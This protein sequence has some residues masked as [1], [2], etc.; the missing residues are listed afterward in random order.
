MKKYSFLF[1]LLTFW[2]VANAQQNPQQPAQQNDSAR[3]VVAQTPPLSMMAKNYGDSVV[4]MWHSGN[5]ALW[6]QH[7]ANGFI[8]ERKEI[9]EGA[10]P[11]RLT[12]NPI[13]AWTP[14]TFKS[15]LDNKDKA[16][17]LAAQA[18]YGSFDDPSTTKAPIF[19]QAE[20]ESERFF[21]ASILGHKVG[22]REVGG[23]SPRRGR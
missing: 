21:V 14:E 2:G 5:A 19:A 1:I 8:I 11:V 22:W 20:A 10:K 13:K 18:L 15:R 17:L 3:I 16:L 12:A 7:Q 6:Q 23:D 9:K 4:L